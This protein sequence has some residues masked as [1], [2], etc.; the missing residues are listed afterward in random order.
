MDL[1]NSVS[2]LNNVGEQRLALLGKLNIFT[3]EDLI[4][5]FPRNYEDRSKITKIAEIS[6]DEVY[7]IKAK[8]YP[9]ISGI[10]ENTAINGKIITKVKLHDGTGLLEAVWFNQPYLKSKFKKG[11]EYIFTGKI[12]I[13]LDKKQI[14]SPDFE[15]VSQKESLS[16][17]RIIPIYLLTVKLSQKML[18][19]FIK[20]CLDEVKE[21]ITDF[22]PR[23]ILQKY[24]LIDRKTAIENIHFPKTNESFFL[25]RRRLVFEELFL[26][27]I[28]LL[29][30]K[31]FIKRKTT[32]KY[33]NPSCEKLLNILPFEMT[34]SQLN[35]I[36]EI[37]KD[38]VDGVLMNRLI[39]G[40]V[41]S[42]KTAIA[43]A[44]AYMVI[45][46]SDNCCQAALMAPTEV[47]TVQHYN[48]FKKYF[49]KLGIETIL[50][51]GSLKRKEKNI[52]LESIS[53]GKSKMIIG[54]H[55][56][57]QQNVEF[58][59]LCLVITDEQH[60]F[61]VRQRITL[62]DKGL[63]PHFL[64]MTATPIPRTLALILY[65]DMDVSVINELPPG[66]QK[67]DTYSVNNSYRTR[68][69]NFIRKQVSEGRQAYII[70]PMIEESETI[71]LNSVLKYTEDLKKILLDLK[72]ECLHG[73]MKQD[74]KQKTMED[75][76]NGEIDVIVSTTVIEVG[77]NVPN[78]TVMLIENAERFGL[79][80]LHQLRGRV[81]RGSDK[82]Y[83]ILIT[84]SKSK[85]CK[86]RM[87][88]MS[89]TGDGFE[90]SEL[91]LDLR[92][93]GDFFGTKQHGIPEFKIANLYKDIS[94]LKEVQEA[95][96]AILSKDFDLNDHENILLKARLSGYL[97]LDNDVISL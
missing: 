71:K 14:E 4:E 54:T 76:I 2:S 79:A 33:E 7:T 81:G 21:Q 27:Q 46:N 77:I 49:D 82:S 15:I 53:S 93:P 12:T 40:D 31:G 66:R 56:L 65:G 57:I 19:T 13:R 63:N 89:K 10:A 75:F 87:E 42:G 6:E 59:N 48:S 17:G 5:Y 39:Q 3:L 55:A 26:M 51:S 29:K 61:G 11:E 28:A 62:K 45:N 23:E 96:V 58:K 25:A 34:S 94:I 9:T 90:I 69:Y 60:R 80:Q 30:M 47:L 20:N 73:K 86:Q 97:N 8:V 68:V 95:A 43:M 70:C 74:I 18:R 84:D 35:V 78:A 32:Q 36:S 67:I 37:K 92:G 24:N 88:A 52:A 83:C 44:T 41:G 50:L 1:S 64:V 16:F 38:F 85:I 22:L 72:I 91:D